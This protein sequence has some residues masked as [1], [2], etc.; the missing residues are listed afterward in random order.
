MS[1]ALAEDT[2]PGGSPNG[3]ERRT[4]D[5]GSLARR[6][7]GVLGHVVVP[8]IA[9]RV[10]VLGALALSHLIVSRTHPT[11]SRAAFGVHQ[12]LLG[13]DAGWY[14]S[15]ASVG[16]GP[17]GHQ[18]L[19][20]FPLFP[21]DGRALGSLPGVTDGAALVILANAASLVGTALLFV[22]VRRELGD[23][24][25]ATRSVWLLSLAPAAFTF[26][27]GY[28]EGLLLVW[29]TACFLAVRPAVGRRPA[30]WWAAGFGMAAAL[31]RPLGILLVLPAS[32][33]ALRWW[34]RAGGIHR[35]SMLAAA[36][37]P[38]AGLLIFLGW[39]QAAVGDLFEPL[40]VQ[41]QSSHHGGLSD[42][43]RTLVHDA[44]GVLHHHFG[45]ALH[46]PWVLIVAALLVVCWWR[47]PASY[48]AF[49]TGAVVMALAGTNLDSF[50]RY[51]LSAFPL[52]VAAA[53]LTPMR[54]RDVERPVFVVASAVL[55]G[56]AVM[57][58]LY[59]SVP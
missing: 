28:V 47:L 49:A 31:T 44:K 34:R 22:L 7:V 57:S 15:I 14:Q 1:Q 29:T 41:S 13:W 30:W 20:F 39:S 6:S 45:T 23:E 10:I 43:L 51:A 8:W 36:S 12:G 46:V 40:R 56:Y 17:L 38:V 33:E 48:G 59:L 24:G 37:G 52:V 21:L 42:P 26:V 5:L 18:S 32:V 50:E 55:A 54:R 53:A 19:R 3:P 25:V 35:V 27:M 58:F 16:Y 9:T 11:G 4:G 2:R